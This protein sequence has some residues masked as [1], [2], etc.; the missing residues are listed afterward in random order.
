MCE[1]K[2][3]PLKL[4]W[5]PTRHN[6]QGITIK[7]PQKV[8]IHGH[9]RIPPSMYY[10][11]FSRAQDLEQVYVENFTKVIKANEKSLEENK[12]LVERSIVPSY[13]ENHFCVFMINIQSLE[14]KTI[15]L[16]NDI[17]ATKADHICVVETWLDPKKETD[18]HINERTL[19]M[20]LMEEVKVVLHF[21][22]KLEKCH[23]IEQ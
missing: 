13:E 6:V 8:V 10:L 2:Q 5:A 16:K 15:D 22:C 17:Y 7:R 19:L 14:N 20:H 21:L 1:L 3:F 11:M 12:N 9:P 4:A 18:I 23:N